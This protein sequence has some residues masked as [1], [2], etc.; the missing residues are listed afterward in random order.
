MLAL[1]ENLSVRGVECVFG[2]GCAFPPGHLGLGVLLDDGDAGFLAGGGD[3]VLDQAAGFG[4]LVEERAGDT[5]PRGDATE[6][7]ADAVPAELAQGV[8]NVADQAGGVLAAGQDGGPACG[9]WLRLG[10]SLGCLLVGG[11]AAVG[12]VGG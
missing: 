2:V 11:L 9:L 12:I 4:V 5:C 6:G 10:R 1:L 3:G 7:D 8:L